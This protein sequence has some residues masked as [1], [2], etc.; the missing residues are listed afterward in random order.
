MLLYARYTLVSNGA[1]PFSTML[2]VPVYTVLQQRWLATVLFVSIRSFFP[3][4]LS[5]SIFPLVSFLLPLPFS[6]TLLLIRSY[7]I[8]RSISCYRPTTLM[9]VRSF[10]IRSCSPRCCSCDLFPTSPHHTICPPSLSSGNGDSCGIFFK[11]ARIQSTPSVL[12]NSAA[13]L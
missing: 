9:L 11:S 1:V 10:S 3:G 7:S 8:I 6:P 13:H 5:F 4:L 2:P 12:P